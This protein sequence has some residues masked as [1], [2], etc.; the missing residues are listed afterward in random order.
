MGSGGSSKVEKGVANQTLV[1]SGPPSA[2]WGH[3]MKN[4]KVVGFAYMFWLLIKM[5]YDF[6]SCMGRAH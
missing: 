1:T 3:G 5:P 6:L 4:R 2:L